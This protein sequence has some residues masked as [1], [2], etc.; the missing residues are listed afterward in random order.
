MAWQHFK[1]VCT[2]APLTLLPLAAISQPTQTVKLVVG[3]AAG[4]PVD[5]AARLFAPAYARELGQPVVVENRP[6]AGGAMGAHA[7]AN[8][9]KA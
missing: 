9:A 2:V 7:T 3:Y 6:G 5:A 8:P 1:I 4:G